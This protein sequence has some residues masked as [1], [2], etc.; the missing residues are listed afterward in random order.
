MTVPNKP[1]KLLAL[2]GKKQVGALSS[3]ERGTLVTAEICMNAAGV[4]MPTMLVF[5]R[6]RSNPQLM[7]RALPGMFAS[8]HPSGWIQMDS[9]VEW[10]KKFILFA[11]PR[12]D[13]PVLLLLDGH[14]S[15]TKNLELVKLARDNNVILL[16]FTLYA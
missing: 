3:A 15:H 7:D 6:V 14:S 9:F 4:Y 2:R 11:N 12:T 16:F 10:F 1:S 5:P 8:Y 13:K